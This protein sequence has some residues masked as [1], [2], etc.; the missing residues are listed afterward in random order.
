MY[1]KYE[2]AVHDFDDCGSYPAKKNVWSRIFASSFYDKAFISFLDSRQ[3]L[4]SW[5]WMCKEK[6]Q[7]MIAWAG[8]QLTPNSCPIHGRPNKHSILNHS[9]NGKIQVDMCAYSVA[10]QPSRRW[11]L[12]PDYMRIY[13]V[14]SLAENMHAPHHILTLRR[15]CSKVAVTRFITGSCFALF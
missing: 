2:S 12:S 6:D 7:D 10:S 5:I 3:S 13:S 15:L 9:R 4:R 1:G 11:E 8:F 14:D